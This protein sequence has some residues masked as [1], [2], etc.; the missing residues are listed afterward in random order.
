MSSESAIVI[1]FDGGGFLMVEDLSRILIFVNRNDIKK[2][3]YI[4]LDGNEISGA[5]ILDIKGRMA[6]T[7][8]R[9]V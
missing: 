4:T 2:I 1:E 7:R 5:T 3:E 6:S 8:V 9:Y